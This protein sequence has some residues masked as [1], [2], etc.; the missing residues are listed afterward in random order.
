MENI[1]ETHNKLDG[2]LLYGSQKK[3]IV[4][5]VTLLN[6]LLYQLGST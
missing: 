1:N 3:S 2:N 4:K 6:H 5:Y